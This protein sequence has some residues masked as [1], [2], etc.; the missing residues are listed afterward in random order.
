MG[1]S[2]II[3]LDR[4]TVVCKHGGIS[5][6]SIA[7]FHIA[8]AFDGNAAL[9]RRSQHLDFLKNLARWLCEIYNLMLIF[10]L[11]SR[12][13]VTKVLTSLQLV[14]RFSVSQVEFYDIS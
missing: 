11:S 12:K 1:G 10:A 3:R 2:G 14:E 13:H 5:A 4:P 8:D 6:T 7:N 9:A